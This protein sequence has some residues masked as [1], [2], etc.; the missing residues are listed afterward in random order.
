[1]S[2]KPLPP[3][4][5]KRPALELLRW[6]DPDK[7]GCR[8]CSPKRCQCGP[9]CRYCGD[10]L[11]RYTV[12]PWPERCSVC[13]FEYPTK[14]ATLL[15]SGDA[16]L[17]AKREAKLEAAVEWW[18]AKRNRS[19]PSMYW[20]IS[21]LARLVDRGAAK[22]RPFEV[23]AHAAAELNAEKALEARLA[24]SAFCDDIDADLDLLIVSWCASR[25]GE[26]HPAPRKW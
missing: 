19:P 15:P 21:S 4:H 6:W 11:N 8:A 14:F 2:A 25:L 17:D 5:P 7:P 1:M 10:Y 26:P 24:C 18:T 3:G 23:F 16:E 22:G 12:R 9:I 13:L 20:V